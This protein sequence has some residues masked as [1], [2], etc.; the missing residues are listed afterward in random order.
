MQTAKYNMTVGESATDAEVR[1]V[2]YI[3][4]VCLFKFIMPHPF[5]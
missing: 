5:I 4:L 2:C 1:S 3:G